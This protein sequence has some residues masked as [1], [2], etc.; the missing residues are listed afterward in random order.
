MGSNFF[1]TYI[2]SYMSYS[3]RCYVA[4]NAPVP[5]RTLKLSSVEPVSTWM[6]DRRGTKLVLLALS[7]E[8]CIS[9]NPVRLGGENYWSLLFGGHLW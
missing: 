1:F 8:V 3:Q 4:L 6:G 7:W 9:C 2:K 5:I